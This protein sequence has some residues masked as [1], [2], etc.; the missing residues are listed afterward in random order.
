MELLKTRL[1]AIPTDANNTKMLTNLVRDLLLEVK[2][3]GPGNAFHRSS[4]NPWRDV[5]FGHI[6]AVGESFKTR[7]KKLCFKIL[8]GTAAICRLKVFTSSFQLHRGL[9][10]ALHPSLWWKDQ[11]A[12]HRRPKAWWIHTQK[13]AFDVLLSGQNWQERRNGRASAD[14]APEH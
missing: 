7:Y 3:T 4:N 2:L 9:I 13:E 8:P 1:Q 6:L 12:N 11:N 14:W 10:A 5:P